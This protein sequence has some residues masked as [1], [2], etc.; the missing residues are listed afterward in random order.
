MREKD[1]APARPGAGP[2]IE[3]APRCIHPPLGLC[4][5]VVG[6]VRTAQ[7]FTVSS[8]LGPT[9]AE[10]CQA[11]H[12]TSPAYSPSWLHPTPAIGGDW[13]PEVSPLTLPLDWSR[14]RRLLGRRSHAWFT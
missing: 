9:E 11:G 10:R 5:L 7:V 14:L 2:V 3:S 12:G 6:R 4:L 1:G 8:V 13:E